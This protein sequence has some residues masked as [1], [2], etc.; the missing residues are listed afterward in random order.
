[1][2]KIERLKKEILDSGLFDSEFYLT[3]YPEVK[4]E[5]IDPIIHYLMIGVQKF[6]N[7]SKN[8]DTKFYLEKNPDVKKIKMNPL[9]HYIRFGKKEGRLP[10]PAVKI[11][12]GIITTGSRKLKD[13]R[14]EKET[15]FYVYIDKER[16]GPAYGRN[17][18]LLNLLARG[19]THIFLFD[20]DCYP[21]MGG[22]EKVFVEEAQKASIDFINLPEYFKD[23]MIDYPNAP[24]QYWNGGDAQFLYLTKHAV[25]TLGAF[26]EGYGRYGFDGIAYIYRAQQAGLCGKFEGVPFPIRGIAYIHAED[27]YGENP[28]VITTSAEKEVFIKKN[29]PIF[30]AEKA[31][32]RRGK[33]FI[34]FK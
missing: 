14:L 25:D 16:K 26:N 11:G 24:I 20:D 6:Y 10:L 13:Y 27:V 19:C 34:P 23:K 15:E 17:Q 21:V 7:P 9:I 8:F 2:L 32:A 31:N 33:W 12:V 28:S 30:D 4:K 5:S 1:M 3:A 29:I 22:W 18:C